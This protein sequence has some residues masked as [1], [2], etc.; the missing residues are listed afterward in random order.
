MSARRRH[1]E[2][3]WTASEPIDEVWLRTL[4]RRRPRSSRRRRREGRG[5]LFRADPAVD[6]AAFRQGRR[7]TR[8]WLKLLYWNEA[9]SAARHW[10]RR[11][12]VSDGDRDMPH[13]RPPRRRPRYPIGD[14]LVIYVTRGERQTCPAVMRVVA[15]P[16]FDPDLV[17]R[18]T[19]PADARKHGWVT[20]VE[21][22]ASTALA[23]APTL[24]EIGVSS[25][26]VGRQGHIHLSREQY[27]N[28]LGLIRGW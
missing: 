19:N 4:K 23:T 14:H 13:G 17:A 6:L 26:S 18:E 8:F 20:W 7:D 24:A 15:E 2:K 10:R 3:W 21:P 12:W 16:V 11:M 5:G 25:Q 22:V 28:A 1:F 27:R 9:R